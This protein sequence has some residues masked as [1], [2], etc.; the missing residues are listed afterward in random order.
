MSVKHL[1]SSGKLAISFTEAEG[2]SLG[3]QEIPQEIVLEPIA[4]V[5][6]GHVDTTLSSVQVDLLS[7]AQK[8]G[9]VHTDAA[10]KFEFHGILPGEYVVSLS[11]VV[12]LWI[13]SNE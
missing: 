13:R 8:I 4:Q 11:D 3:K 9:S 6:S 7:G 12:E 1:V 5:I 10:H 2:V